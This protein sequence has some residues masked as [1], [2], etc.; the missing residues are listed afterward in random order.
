MPS[1]IVLRI[2]SGKEIWGINGAIIPLRILIVLKSKLWAIILAI[3][4][5]IFESFFRGHQM[6]LTYMLEKGGELIVE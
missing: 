6:Q 3:S 1:G 5:G 4:R 2:T